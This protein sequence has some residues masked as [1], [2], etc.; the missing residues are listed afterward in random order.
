MP[1]GHRHNGHRISAQAYRIATQLRYGWRLEAGGLIDVVQLS[2][3]RA[4]YRNIEFPIP[5]V[6]QQHA[7]F[8]IVRDEGQRV[9]IRIVR[10]S[11]NLDL[12]VAWAEIVVKQL[13]HPEARVW[14]AVVP[15][16]HRDAGELRRKSD[17]L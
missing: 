6:N 12:L 16:N 3:A 7:M 13:E 5:F 2:A 10:H 14:L 17:K 9:D 8:A 1:L 4:C 15:I 11:L